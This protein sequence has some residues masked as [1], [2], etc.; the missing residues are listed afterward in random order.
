MRVLTPAR[1]GLVLVVAVAA[2]LRLHGLAP[3]PDG[4][5]QDEAVNGYDAFCLARTGLDH[6]GNHLPLLLQSF[7]DWVSPLLTYVT[8][9]FVALG[10]L[11]Q[12]TTRLP[13]ALANTAA[14]AVVY[15]LVRDLT[16]SRAWGLV[17]ATIFAVAPWDVALAQWAAPP[18][19][20]P[21][22]AALALWC[23][24]RAAVAPGLRWALGF[25]VAAA[26]LVYAYPTQ[27]LFAPLFVLAT[28]PFVRGLRPRLAALAVF[29]LLAAPMEIA[30][31]A[32]RYN[33]RFAF[34]GLD[35]HD[36]GFAGE[37]LQRYG[38]YFTPQF[39]FRNGSLSFPPFFE[40][41]LAIGFVLLLLGLVVA[42]G[43][44][45]LG[46][47]RAAILFA[48]VVL[49]PLPA[50][51][52]R[53]HLHLTRMIHALPIVVVLLTLGL[54]PLF[55]A[56]APLWPRR[57]AAAALAVLFAGY[58]A[59]FVARDTF[60]DLANR[61]YVCQVGLG[62]AL[63][64][65]AARSHGETV[66]VDATPNQGFNQP[67]IYYLYFVRRDPAR[68][69]FAQMEASLASPDSWS[70]VSAIDNFRFRAIAPG[71]LARTTPVWDLSFG[72]GS[73][74]ALRRAGTTLYLLHG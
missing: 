19:L 6:H 47:R 69:P 3:V 60:G 49:A 45:P 64:Y 32:P 37:V 4:L 41:F 53:D 44:P 23:A 63:Q 27:K 42:R 61:I 46:R 22:L 28:L 25:A 68:L 67:Y 12:V 59:D 24:L 54:T 33:A 39:L 36:P 43:D 29:A 31:L 18:T 21:L 1:L 30:S 55:A 40:P 50:S 34:V 65:V 17:A 38:E 26:L 11:S 66:V 74:F 20:L 71:E 2:F 62:A 10:G 15:L 9:P 48:F 73:A 51:L 16:A 35:V 58:T 8:V 52:T 13:G 57:A 7:G 5:N 14:V 56:Q 72:G 70:Y